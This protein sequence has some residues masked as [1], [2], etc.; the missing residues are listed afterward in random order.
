MPITVCYCPK[1]FHQIL[2]LC[3]HRFQNQKITSLMLSKKKKGSIFHFLPKN[4]TKPTVR[5]SEMSLSCRVVFCWLSWWLENATNPVICQTLW[6][7]PSWFFNNWSCFC[8]HS[9]SVCVTKPPI[10]ALCLGS[11]CWDLE[12]ITLLKRSG[13]QSASKNSGSR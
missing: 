13:K 9:S 4:M 2:F 12:A 11:G 7:K 3:Q 8:L 1:W 5:L 10:F 6:F